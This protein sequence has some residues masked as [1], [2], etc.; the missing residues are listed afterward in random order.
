MHASG[1]PT[2]MAIK[3]R[4]YVHFLKQTLCS[5]ME[6]VQRNF[7]LIMLWRPKRSHWVSHPYHMRMSQQDDF[8]QGW[9]MEQ[10]KLNMFLRGNC[11]H[12]RHKE[13]ETRSAIKCMGRKN[14]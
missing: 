3:K 7:L 9:H 6:E 13:N 14:N 5:F 12:Q 1:R 10:E 11:Y 4:W 2:V 8:V